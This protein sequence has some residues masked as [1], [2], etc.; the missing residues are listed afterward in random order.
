MSSPASPSIPPAASTEP[1]PRPHAWLRGAAPTAGLIVIGC[2]LLLQVAIVVSGVDAR[3]VPAVL[4]MVG[5]LLIALGAYFG[6]ASPIVRE[7]SI[8]VDSP[9]RGRWQAVNSPASATPSHGLH[10]L[11]QTWAVDLIGIPDDR[12]RP[13]YG[14]TVTGYLPPTDFPG[15]G[16][17]VHAVADATVVARHDAE[18]DHKTRYSWDAILYM[19]VIEG[20]LR[21]IGGPRKMIGNHVV[22]RLD[23]GT[24]F[25]YGH[26]QRGSVRVNVGDRMRAGDVLAACGNSGNSSEPHLHVQRQDRS[27][28]TL[29]TGLPWAIRGAGRGGRDGFP[30]NGENWVSE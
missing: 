6:S 17:P 25:T 5:A 21:S 4:G 16:L 13:V 29:A 28:A 27:G 9:V 15:F 19:T 26:L 14:R 30:L 23:D 3:L 22:L 10:T 18:V 2:A 24:F 8:V 11:G 20:F 1:R 7:G 12:H